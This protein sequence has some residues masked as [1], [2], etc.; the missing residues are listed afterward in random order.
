VT[1]SRGN[2]IVVVGIETNISEVV[3]SPVTE[4]YGKRLIDL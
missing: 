2:C 1:V 3:Y 4:S